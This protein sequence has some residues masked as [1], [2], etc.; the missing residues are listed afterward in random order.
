MLSTCHKH[1]AF[2]CYHFISKTVEPILI[3]FFAIALCDFTES[4]QRSC[5]ATG[6]RCNRLLQNGFNKKKCGGGGMW[7][8]NSFFRHQK[9][10]LTYLKSFF[11]VIK[12]IIHVTIGEAAIGDGK[13]L[14]V[15]FDFF[16]CCI[17]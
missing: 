5:M 12:T 16:T 10:I 17:N 1:G 6:G 7:C 13:Q 14:P 15:C 11:E 8:G 9:M 4:S 2:F 3:R